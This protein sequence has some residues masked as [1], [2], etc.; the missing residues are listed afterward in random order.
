MGSLGNTNARLIA[1]RGRLRDGKAMSIPGMLGNAGKPGSLGSARL[2]AIVGNGMLSD[3]NCRS[4]P[5]MLGRFGSAGN[6]G[7]ATP[8]L[9][10][11]TGRLNEGNGGMEHLLM[12]CEPD[13][14]GGQREPKVALLN[15]AQ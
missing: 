1:G 11:G 2:K 6:A 10:A 4:T 7:S 9:T 14:K 15:R 5:G 8:K 12:I 3:G 13:L